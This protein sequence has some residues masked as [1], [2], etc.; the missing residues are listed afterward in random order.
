MLQ[1]YLDWL[2]LRLAN[3]QAIMLLSLM[4]ISTGL[5]TGAVI[6][7]FRWLLALAQLHVLGAEAAQSYVTLDNTTRLVLPIAGAVSLALLFWLIPHRY[8]PVGVLHVFERLQY[9]QGRMQGVNMVLQFFGAG[10][11]LF[12]GHS[13]GREGPSIH[14]GAYS[15]SW[16][17]QRLELPNNSTRTLVACGVAAAIGASFNT[18]L[19]GIIFA[20]EVIMQ[21]YAAQGF[22]PIMLAAVSGTY[23]SRSLLG[24][25]IFFSVTLDQASTGQD[26]WLAVLLGIL[27]G[28][29]SA[30]FNFTLIHLTRWS[31][32]YPLWQRFLLAGLLMG[33]LG[34]LF[35]ACMGIG[36][37]QLDDMLNAQML[38]NT[39][40]VVLISKFTASLVCLGLGIPGGMIGPL[41]FIGT[42][43][44]AV[45]IT[46]CYYSSIPLLIPAEPK[47][48]PL[49]GMAAMF[50]A[51]LQ[52]PLAGLTAVM[53]LSKNADIILPAMLGIVS[54]NLTSKVLFGHDSLFTSLLRERG[55]GYSTDIVSQ[56]LS[57]IGAASIM[58]RDILLCKQQQ[59]REQAQQLLAQEKQWLILL[60]AERRP[61]SLLRTL[62]L[63]SFME[64]HPNT[65]QIDL[66]EIPGTRLQ[67]S[68]LSVR[69]NLHEALQAL[70]GSAAEALYLQNDKSGSIYGVLTRER[71]ERA[72]A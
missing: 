68:C 43:A 38:L 18:P 28:G 23:L 13:V 8:R 46:A 11:A 48:Y 33:A 64:L 3:P 21:Q 45:F 69:A 12:S 20:M 30:G 26:W 58:N 34:W 40:V 51:S 31:I 47:M 66:N 63:H 15:G 53:E 5:L 7:L 16:L 62:D 60:N 6:V 17:A 36:Y 4:A 27:I 54:A 56:R 57:L 59:T 70:K 71:L 72:C 2:R 50:S 65:E 24:E 29:L 44:G 10:I 9:H 19:A 42:A 35:P 25:E 61:Y 1:T 55:L 14:M 52:A 67:L 22:V 49:I 32:Q 41:M 37:D 39:L